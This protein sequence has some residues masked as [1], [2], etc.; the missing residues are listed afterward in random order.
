MKSATFHSLEM[1]GQQ[2]DYRLVTSRTAR[3]LRVRV[4]LDGIEVVR[5]RLRSQKEAEA[6]LRR[7]EEWL[8][9]QM[10]RIERLRVV[11]R[12]SLER[13]GE[14]L[15]RGVATPVRLVNHAGMKGANRIEWDG[16]TI[17]VRQSRTS[18]TPVAK[19]LENW[20][21]KQVKADIEVHLADVTKRL[22]RAPNRVYVMAQRTKWGNCSTLR[23]LSF[24]WRLVLAPEYV[25]RY[26]VTHE[27]VHLSIPDHS[28]KFWLT[29]Q[30]L[31]PEMEKAKAWLRANERELKINLQQVAADANLTRRVTRKD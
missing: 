25:L 12:P 6:F 29:V 28:A 16:T 5:P 8:G 21:R 1:N 9:D 24:N 14:M 23:N 4:G 27:A 26:V 15:F 13:K 3:R 7:H 20:L 11:R 2:V 18:R 19:S 22:G 17:A 10:A 31:C 30:S